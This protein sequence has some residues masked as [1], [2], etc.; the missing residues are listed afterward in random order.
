MEN[1]PT[2]RLEK[3]MD[4]GNTEENRSTSGKNGAGWKTPSKT[5]SFEG[6]L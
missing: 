2:I 4:V 1:N 6:H 5:E 3:A